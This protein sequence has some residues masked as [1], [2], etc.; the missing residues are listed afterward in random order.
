MTLTLPPDGHKFIGTTNVVGP[1]V[2]TGRHPVGQ[3]WPGT[4]DEE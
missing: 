1:V 3:F 4:L 2:R